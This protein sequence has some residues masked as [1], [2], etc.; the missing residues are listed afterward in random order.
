MDL[1]VSNRSAIAVNIPK[2]SIKVR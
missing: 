2:D 1:P